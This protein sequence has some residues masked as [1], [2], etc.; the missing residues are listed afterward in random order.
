MN[1]LLEMRGITKTF[2]GVVANDNVGLEVSEGEIHALLG[3]NGAGKTTLMNIL[4]GLY[5]C[6]SGEIYFK[7][8]RVRV[9]S[10]Q[11]AITLG[12]G[13]VHQEFMLV[14][15]LTVAENVALGLNLTNS[16]LL[17]LDQVDRGIRD[18]SARHG[19]GLDP[20][21]KIEHLSV[22]VQQ[23]VEIVKLLY[24]KARLLILDEPTAVLTPQETDGLFEVLRSLVAEGRSAILITHKLNEVMA[25]SDRVTVLRDGK[26]VAT[27]RT[28]DTDQYELA[29]MMVGREVLFQARKEPL[30]P[31]DTLL[32]VENLH[33][34][35]D[36]GLPALK[37]ASFQIRAG[38]I[39]GVAGV[40]GNGQRELA[41][42]L[43][44]LRPATRG[45]ISVAGLDVTGLPPLRRYS[46]G[47]AYVPADRRG[48]GCIGSLSVAQNSILGR[49]QEFTIAGGLLLS[50]ARV[51]R[52]A[53]ELV[54]SF[55]VRCP[56]VDVAASKLSGGNLQKLMLGRELTRRP[57]VLVVEQ[58]TRG[59]DVAATEYVRNTILEARRSGAAVLLVSSELDEVLAL[60]DRISV[61][62]EGRIMATLQNDQHL[63]VRM[64]GLMMAGANRDVDAQAGGSSAFTATDPA[65]GRR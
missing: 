39:L 16:P 29:E 19:L 2:P 59:L 30:A 12:I 15:A 57:K 53:S 35:D 18:L 40:A 50:G 51:R 5:R 26:V 38:E 7:G 3:E 11:D 24:R 27:Q 4:Y 54:A 62:Y 17:E 63:D 64:I 22:G 23:R 55:D 52:H 49:C 9:R 28:K 56:G 45:T 46:R 10:P 37:G 36:R 34:S 6:D 13:M 20:R 60:S 33:V 21:A 32:E 48:V 42:A 65:L 41:E 58:P 25:I 14:P 61:I 44:G 47:L 8:A 1:L 43:A 31:E